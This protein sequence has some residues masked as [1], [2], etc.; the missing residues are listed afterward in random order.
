MTAYLGAG[1]NPL[2]SPKFRAFDWI[3][4]DLSSP[5]KADWQI[6]VEIFLDRLEGRFLAPIQAIR[7]HSDEHIAT[8]SGFAIVAIDCLIIETLMQFRR[9]EEETSGD[10]KKAF[11][12]FFASSSHFKPYFDSEQKSFLFYNHFRNGLLHQAQTKRRSLIRIGEDKMVEWSDPLRPEE[13]LVLDREKFH[14]ALLREIQDYAE[15]IRTPKAR[16]DFV[17]R[18]HFTTKMNLI[19]KAAANPNAP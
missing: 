4:L 8:F 7:K 17:L 1:R 5:Q 3:N 18:G 12:K 19:A 6:A 13:G 14:E 15:G 9:G 11:A 2:I 10:H 16:S